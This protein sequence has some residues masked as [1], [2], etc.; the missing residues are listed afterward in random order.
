MQNG[1]A[2]AKLQRR[3][4]ATAYTNA[5]RIMDAAATAA[6][7]EHASRI[8][9]LKNFR[10]TAYPDFSPETFTRAV[11]DN[12]RRMQWVVREVRGRRLGL[13]RELDLSSFYPCPAEL[14]LLLRALVEVGGEGPVVLRLRSCGL[15]NDCRDQL[16]EWMR[17]GNRSVTSVDLSCNFL[18]MEDI[19]SFAKAL[20]ENVTGVTL[21]SL[22]LSNC[23]TGSEGMYAVGKASFSSCSFSYFSYFSPSPA[24]LACARFPLPLPTTTS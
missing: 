21:L 12:T 6:A 24:P 17:S 11:S 8:E 20:R 9:A 3:T 23:D 18:R 10:R 15:R 13:H 4:A 5:Q 2:P 1:Q 22:N 14:D 7:A 16:S 19:Q